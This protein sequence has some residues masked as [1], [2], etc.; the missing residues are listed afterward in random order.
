MHFDKKTASPDML[1]SSSSLAQWEL[2][3]ILKG[4]LALS[5]SVLT[6]SFRICRTFK[7]FR[8]NLFLSLLLFCFDI[9][10][11]QLNDLWKLFVR[12]YYLP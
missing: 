3:R 4:E 12:K 5:I 11:L 8:V 10:Y 7:K 1:S 9:S 6:S 2:E